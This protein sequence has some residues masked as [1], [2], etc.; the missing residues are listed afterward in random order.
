MRAQGE[1]VEQLFRMAAEFGLA[2]AFW[3]VFVRL[4][5]HL[6]QTIVVPNLERNARRAEVPVAARAVLKPRVRREH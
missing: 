3:A 1:T 2:V 6:L 5:F 4:S